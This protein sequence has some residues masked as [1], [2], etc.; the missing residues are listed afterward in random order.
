VTRSRQW[1]VLSLLLVLLGGIT[2]A[3]KV[4]RLGYPVLPDE[5][6]EQWLVQAR[7]EIEP[8]K[9]PV[10]ASLLL[11][12]R[13]TGFTVTNESFIS[14]DFGLTLEENMFRR[15]ADWAIRS[16]D[17]DRV[18]YYRVLATAG[19]PTGRRFRLHLNS[20]SLGPVRWQTWCR[21]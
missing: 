16:L 2:F 3:Y 5:T 18:L 11:P 12:V 15:Q 14:R 4:V 19:S 10:R 9:G 8:V 20:T 1:V 6:G 21:K 17:S 13:S 7:L